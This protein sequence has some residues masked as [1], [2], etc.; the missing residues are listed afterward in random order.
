VP[1]WMF[2]ENLTLTGIRSPDRP[3]CEDSLYR[4]RYPGPRFI[5]CTDIKSQLTESAVRRVCTVQSFKH[6]GA[7][8]LCIFLYWYRTVYSVSILRCEIAVKFFRN[9]V[10]YK[11]AK[12]TRHS[13]KKELSF[14]L[15]DFCDFM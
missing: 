6:F 9:L 14:R 2:V 15:T 1:V 5:L 4:L 7:L 11:Y 12:R 13:G 8:A 10:E 3:A